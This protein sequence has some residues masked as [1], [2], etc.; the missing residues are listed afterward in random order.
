[1]DF[2]LEKL[3]SKELSQLFQV[4]NE[5]VEG[6]EA[7]IGV[8]RGIAIFGSARVKE[9]HAHYE[10][11]R[12]VSKLL[13]KNGHTI[14]TGGGPGIMQ[15]ANQGAKEG[16]G[17]SVGL[18]IFLPN[19]QVYNDYLDINIGFRHF[20]VRKLMFAKY[21]EAY[22]IMPGGMGTVDEFS[23]AMVLMQTQKMKTSPII[24]YNKKYWSGFLDWIKD[25]MVA[26]GY[27]TEEELDIIYLADS[28]EEVL[29][30]TK[31]FGITK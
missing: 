12:K 17:L 8:E 30:I 31:K 19:E 21:S 14:I 11:T 3:S 29:E 16:K 1:M 27:L 6:F 2:E 13:A 23:D 5:L 9:G 10:D 22:V 18:H 25:N 26:E 28:P 4:M 15:A 24:F 20:F 7:L